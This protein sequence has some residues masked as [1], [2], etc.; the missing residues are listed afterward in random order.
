MCVA[1]DEP[2]ASG[3]GNVQAMDAPKVYTIQTK[4]TCETSNG[5]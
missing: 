2:E 5:M 3:D 4:K 1:K